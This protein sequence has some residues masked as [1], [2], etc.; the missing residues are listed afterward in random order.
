MR[1]V[2]YF[3]IRIQAALQIQEMLVSSLIMQWKKNFFM[4]KL[5]A[6]CDVEKN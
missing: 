3:D 2:L 1:V 4:T 5:S 6:K